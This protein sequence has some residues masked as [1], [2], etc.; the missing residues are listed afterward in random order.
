MKETMT[1]DDK[2]RRAR[3]DMD[4]IRQYAD[5]MKDP[6]RRKYLE[7]EIQKQNEIM[8]EVDKMMKKE[9]NKNEKK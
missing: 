9:G 6:E 8:K 2:Q 5:V 1:I 3:W 7:N 4:N